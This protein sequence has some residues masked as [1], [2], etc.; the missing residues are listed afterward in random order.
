MHVKTHKT[1]KVL[2]SFTKHGIHPLFS[3]NLPIKHKKKLMNTHFEIV[4]LN[5]ENIISG[6]IAEK[7]N[8]IVG[9]QKL[10]DNSNSS[11]ESKFSDFPELIKTSGTLPG[12][13]NIVIDPDAIAVIHAPSRRPSSLKLRII[14]KL[15]EMEQNAYITK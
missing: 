15:K 10:H 5:Q 1:N 9:I 2:K 14:E 4:D 12:Q 13:H 7:S 11:A 3:V 6:N 8:L